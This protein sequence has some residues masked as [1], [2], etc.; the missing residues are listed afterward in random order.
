MFVC[1]G[2]EE[3]FPFA[4]PMG[5]GLEEMAINLTKFLATRKE[6]PENLLFVGT[7]GSYGRATI[8]DI[9]ESKTASQIELSFLQKQSYT[10]IDNVISTGES[11]T[12]VN[13][14]NYITSDFQLS[15]KML[16]LKIDLENMEFFAF[17]QVAK[18]FNIPAG[19]VFIV[20]NFT[21]QNAHTDFKFN[22]QEAMRRVTRYI[23]NRFKF[24]V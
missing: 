16:N 21:N 19:G 24:K 13:S 17:L 14:S 4:L 23:E 8:F 3:S 9:V 10:P 6:L 5:I 20:T 11:Q 1:A 15:K 2:K 18:S 12:I 7:A 22:H